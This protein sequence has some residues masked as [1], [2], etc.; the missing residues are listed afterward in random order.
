MQLAHSSQGLL[1]AENEAEFRYIAE[2]TAGLVALG[3]PFRGTKMQSIA[4]VVAKLMMLSGAHWG[5]L[6]DLAYDNAVLRDKLD[7][8]C[9]LQKRTSM[10]ACCFFELYSTD[11]GRRF[12]LPGWFRGMVSILATEAVDN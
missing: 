6:R 1:F 11:Y 12:G 5:I 9:R 2:Q 4:D 7:A 10:L 8:F 3:C